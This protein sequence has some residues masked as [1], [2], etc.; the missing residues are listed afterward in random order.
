MRRR[1]L[2]ALGRTRG[3]N[4]HG[5]NPS[6]CDHAGKVLETKADIQRR[7][8]P[9]TSLR[10]MRAVALTTRRP[11]QA[12]VPRRVRRAALHKA[13]TLKDEDIFQFALNLEYMETEYYLRVRRQGS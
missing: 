10:E 4:R 3:V 5:L 8:Q 1:A 7:N 13:R 2:Q 11:P 6:A 12:C 9:F